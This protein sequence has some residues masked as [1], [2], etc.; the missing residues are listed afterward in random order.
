MG[1]APY[2]LGKVH[3]F[4]AAGYRARMLGVTI[5]PH[6]GVVRAYIRAKQGGRYVPVQ[7]LLRAHQG[8]NEALPTYIRELGGEST[9]YDNSSDK[10]VQISQEDVMNGK[11]APMSQRAKVDPKATNL[12]DLLSPTGNPWD[13]TGASEDRHRVASSY[14]LGPNRPLDFA[15]RSR[16]R[17]VS[18]LA[19]PYREV[20]SSHLGGETP[21]QIGARMGANPLNVSRGAR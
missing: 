18:G 20:H 3:R 13:R 10:P 9:I 6:E 2:A 5:D 15:A 14:V 7:A 17:I 4:K 19:S 21:E 8:F 11:Y 1:W 16:D 12:G